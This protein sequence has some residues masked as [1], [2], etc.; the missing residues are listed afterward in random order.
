MVG[1][2]CVSAVVDSLFVVAPIVVCGGWRVVF[3]PCFVLQYLVYFLVLQ[4]SSEEER[5]GCF[6]SNCLLYIMW[7]L[8]FCVS[9]SRCRG[10][11]CCVLSWHLLIRLTF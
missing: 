11:V 8:V 9:S 6:N 2:S 5:A 10:L 4:S 3:S 7:L 1:S